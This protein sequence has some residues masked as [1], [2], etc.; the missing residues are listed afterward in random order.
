[1][2]GYEMVR[3]AASSIFLAHHPAGR[4]TEALML[5]PLAMIVFT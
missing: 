3:S 5:V 1:M 2:I 4:L